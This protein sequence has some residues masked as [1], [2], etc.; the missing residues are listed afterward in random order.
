MIRSTKEFCLIN[1]PR[2]R[3]PRPANTKRPLTHHIKAVPALY[4]PSAV[5]IRRNRTGI[6]RSLRE[7]VNLVTLGTNSGP[8][9]AS[10][11]RQ[12]PRSVSRRRCRCHPKIIRPTRPAMRRRSG[13]RS[14]RKLRDRRVRCRG[15]FKFKIGRPLAG[16]KLITG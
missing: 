7:T 2:N 9:A 6:Y 5:S 8:P 16:R 14:V 1:S 15:R 13:R 3:L 11:A 10:A 12:I 4:P